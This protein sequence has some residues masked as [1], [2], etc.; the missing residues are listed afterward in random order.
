L[1]VVLYPV[2]WLAGFYGF[3]LAARLVLGFWPQYNRPDPKT[4]WWA[5]FARWALWSGLVLWPGVAALSVLLALYGLW[6]FKSPGFAFLFLI[7]LVGNVLMV[8]FGRSD[9]GGFF[10]WFVD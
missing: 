9:P 5:A 3:V 4:L 1:S 7:A 10:N 8:A 6:R 2:L